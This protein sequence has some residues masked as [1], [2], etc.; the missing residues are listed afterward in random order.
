MALNKKNKNRK[1]EYK[2]ELLERKLLD[3]VIEA[4]VEELTSRIVR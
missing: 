2:A 3:G 4:E 1:G